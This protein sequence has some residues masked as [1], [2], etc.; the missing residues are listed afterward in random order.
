MNWKDNSGKKTYKAQPETKYY[1]AGHAVQSQ[2]SIE[3][4]I[5]DE[6]PVGKRPLGRPRLRWED[7]I[8]KNVGALN[9]GP[10]WKTRA[11]DGE[12]WKI[13]CVMVWS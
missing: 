4:M 9:G 10:D 3:R 13:G 12:G 2:N 5:I 6:N 7:M 1:S 8:R 11:T